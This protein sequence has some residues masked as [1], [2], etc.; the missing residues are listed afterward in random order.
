MIEIQI[1]QWKSTLRD[2]LGNPDFDFEIRISH[3]STKSLLKKDFSSYKSK[4]EFV[5]YCE[6]RNQT[7]K[8]KSGVP[9]E[10]TLSQHLNV[11]EGNMKQV[12][13]S[14]CGR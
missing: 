8:K 11:C 2:R 10:S 14:V 6:V 12:E 7:L 1:S 9:I 5:F 13:L 3:C 4:T